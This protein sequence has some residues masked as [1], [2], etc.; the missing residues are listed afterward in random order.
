MGTN[1]PNIFAPKIAT[2]VESL[3]TEGKVG[4]CAGSVRVTDIKSGAPSLTNIPCGDRFKV[5]IPYAGNSLTWEIIFNSCSPDD[6]PDF[7]FSA[8]DK[9]FWPQIENISHLANWDNT[10]PRSLFLVIQELLEEYKKYHQSLKDENARLQ[11]EYNALMEQDNFSPENVEVWVNKKGNRLGPI[12]FLMRLDVDF[13]KIPPYL[14]GCSPGEDS[15]VLL[16]TFQ[17]PDGGKVLPQLYLSPRVEHALGGA[18]N[19]R[20]PAFPSGGCLIDYVPNVRELLK[21]KVDQIVQGHDRRKEYVAACLS[22]F[23]RSIIEY[24]AES[25]FK[26]SFLLEWN[27][28]FFI[29]HIELPLYFPVDSPSLTVQSVYHE[30]GGRPYSKVTREYP[31]SP[32]WSGN[33]MVERVRTYLLENIAAFQRASVQNGSLS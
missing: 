32:R 33:E 26:I 16:V 20:I 3:L 10:N 29:V 11:W 7:L 8:E 25:F 13:S 21:N 23:G 6:P 18:A 1:L 4:I 9:D 14:I 2:F 30:S 5:V 15:A 31:Y 22:A 12:N 19:L 27:D 28:F 17:Y 24:D